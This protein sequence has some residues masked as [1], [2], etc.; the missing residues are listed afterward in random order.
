MAEKVVLLSG[1]RTAIGRFGG[2]LKDVP[3]QRLGSI[4]ILEAVSQTGTEFLR[5]GDW[6]EG[7]DAGLA[8]LGE[9]TSVSSLSVLRLDRD[10]VGD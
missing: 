7:A 3:P 8:R 2:A 1:V 5:V 10:R 4:A 6:Q 9:A